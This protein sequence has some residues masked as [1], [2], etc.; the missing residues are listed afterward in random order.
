MQ[1]NPRN[2][3]ASLKSTGDVS[4]ENGVRLASL[5]PVLVMMLTRVQNLKTRILEILTVF[6]DEDE[7]MAQGGCG[8]EAVN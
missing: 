4:F 5:T 3:G 6:G 1:L 2:L 7:L 8:N